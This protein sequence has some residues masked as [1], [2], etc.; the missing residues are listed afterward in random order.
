MTA[1][2]PYIPNRRTVLAGAAA[3][4]VIAAQGV[5]FS[6]AATPG[7]KRLVVVLLRGGLDGLALFPPFGDSDYSKMRAGLALPRANTDGGVLDLDGSFGLHPAAEDLLAFWSAGELVIAPAAVTDYRGGSHFAAQDAL[8]TGSA[9]GGSKTGWLNRA[10]GAL[11]SATGKGVTVSDDVPLILRG[12]GNA[13]AATPP[14]RPY[15]NPGF[16][17]QV[18]L[19]YGD[20]TLFSSMIVQ[21]ERDRQRTTD[22]VTAEDVQ[23]GRGADRA[24]FLPIAAAMAGKLLAS[25]DG[26]RVAVLEADGWDT[27]WDQGA[28]DGRLARSF[29]GLASGLSVL[30]SALGPA[31]KETVVVVASEFGRTVKPNAHGGTDHGFATSAMMLGGAV[32]GGKIVGQWPGLSDG[33]LDKTGGIASGFDTRSLFKTALFHHMGINGN[34]VATTVLPGTASAPGIPG[35]IR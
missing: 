9:G 26:P 27:H 23:S 10:V 4:T 21:G 16:F 13:S 29:S 30:A 31:W 17:R 34:T 19:L 8:E 14:P 25:D 18:Q 3:A 2:T 5:K 1:H 15:R 7:N 11:G 33:K 32:A 22:T 28:M 24:Q 6:V 12:P 20:D 35:L